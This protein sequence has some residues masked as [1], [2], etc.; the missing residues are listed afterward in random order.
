[1][2][3]MTETIEAHPLHSSQYLLSFRIVRCCLHF[4]LTLLIGHSLK[5]AFHLLFFVSLLPFRCFSC[6]LPRF[7]LLR[8]LI[9][10]T[11]C[12]EVLH[13]RILPILLLLLLFF[14][15]HH[16]LMRPVDFVLLLLSPFFLSS[17]FPLR[18]RSN[19]HPR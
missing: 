10:R 9:Q 3:G 17:L 16:R 11:S 2:T 4:Q 8:S 19:R 6:L 12:T 1:M 7:L 15:F 18:P 14:F 13:T 5:Q